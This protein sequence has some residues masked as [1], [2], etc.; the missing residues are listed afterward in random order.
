MRVQPG[1]IRRHRRSGPDPLILT[2]HSLPP[3]QKAGVQCPNTLFLQNPRVW[4]SAPSSH[5]DRAKNPGSQ[6]HQPQDPGIP[7]PRHPTVLAYGPTLPAG[8]QLSGPH[9]AWLGHAFA[10]WRRSVPRCGV[11][12]LPASSDPQPI[13]DSSWV[14][15]REASMPNP[16]LRSWKPGPWAQVLTVSGLLLPQ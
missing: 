4:P 7:A 11:C 12:V 1:G 15:G 9:P 5:R 6:P 10:L 13:W 8:L 3:P 14:S 2:P 16:R